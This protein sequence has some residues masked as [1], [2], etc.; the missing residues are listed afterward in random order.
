M[1]CPLQWRAHRSKQEDE[2]KGMGLPP[3]A[4]FAYLGQYRLQCLV[5]IHRVW[6]LTLYDY[7]IVMI[8][9]CISLCPLSRFLHHDKMYLSPYTLYFSFVNDILAKYTISVRRHIFLI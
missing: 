6:S 1:K 9:F 2:E 5:T 4:P 7:I 8:Y 3:L